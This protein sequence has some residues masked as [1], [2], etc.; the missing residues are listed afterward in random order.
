MEVIDRVLR[1]AQQLRNCDLVTAHELLIWLKSDGLDRL[2][3]D[4]TRYLTEMLATPVKLRIPVEGG[5]LATLA[6]IAPQKSLTVIKVDPYHNLTYNHDI[7]VKRGK[8][9]NSHGYHFIAIDVHGTGGS[10]DHSSDFRLSPIASDEYTRQETQDTLKAIEYIVRQPWSDGRIVPYG[11]SYSG[12]TALQA[13]A[14]QSPHIVSA[15]VMHATD[16]RW[17]TDVHWWGGGCNLHPTSEERD[18]RASRS[19]EK[20]TPSFWGGSCGLHPINEERDAKASR[21]SE[22]GAPP[23]CG[24][25]KTVTDWLEYATAMT[26]FNLLSDPTQNPRPWL[27]NWTT[28]NPEYW[29]IG[30]VTP[31]SLNA[32]VCPPQKRETIP[33]REH[34]ITAPVFLYGGF[35]DL[36]VDAMLRLHTDLPRNITVVGH[37]GHVPP[38]THDEW[39]IWWLGHYSEVQDRTLYYLPQSLSA[40]GKET[41]SWIQQVSSHSVH[42]QSTFKDPQSVPLRLIC[43]P[44]FRYY[45]KSV[46]E[47]TYPLL[48]QLKDA[49]LAV[50]FDLPELKGFVAGSLSLKVQLVERFDG[51]LVAWLLDDSGKLF[52]MGVNRTMTDKLKIDMAPICLTAASFSS[53]TLYLSTSNVPNLVPQFWVKT[54]PRVQTC[55]LCFSVCEMK[56]VSGELFPTGTTEVYIDPLLVQYAKFKDDQLILRTDKSECS[57]K[58]HTLECEDESLDMTVDSKSLNAIFIDTAKSSLTGLEIQTIT[59]FTASDRMGHLHL[60]TTVNGQFHSKWEQDFEL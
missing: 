26:P 24:G 40:M 31:A 56:P 4:L 53:T 9:L 39:L 38:T 15:F 16:D 35:H 49:G 52:S 43:G 11:L 54:P 17:R 23:F 57:D 29:K 37:S 41:C 18:A 60:T 46:C 6:F 47:E 19:S 20:G 48:E 14:K 50:K 32:S 27:L 2:Q 21:S 3:L 55:E 25:V 30:S 58:S 8:L 51:Y 13:A 1:I 59:T 42:V 22:K 5:T 28:K 45:A 44:L 7:N 12:F 10:L 34:P 33:I 36:Y